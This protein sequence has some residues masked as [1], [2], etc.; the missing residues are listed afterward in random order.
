M[1]W[2]DR[3][4]PVA[5]DGRVRVAAVLVL[6]LVSLVAVPARAYADDLDVDP[7]VTLPI[8]LIG[9]STY[10]AGELVL[11]DEISPSTCRW[12]ASNR[13][14][15]GIRDGLRWDDTNLAHQ[16]SNLTGFAAAPVVAFGGIALL[17]EL[18]DDAG[19]SFGDDA[20]VILEAAV[21]TANINYVIKAAVGRERPF[22]HALPA[23]DKPHT[24][25]PSDNNLSF[26]SGHSAWSMSLAVSAGT[27][28]SIRGYDWAPALWAG[29]VGVSL[30]TGYLRIAADK[31]WATDVLVG[32]AA[33][34]AV[35]YL[36]PRL[37][38]R[39]D[40]T[41]APVIAVGGGP[42]APTLNLSFTW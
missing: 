28:A 8:V 33:G 17:G 12:C 41:G 10:A 37:H 42:R 2:V 35:G 23:A 31:H 21:I 14:D 29:G 5:D 13:F 25:A 38:R 20:L 6:V 11:K 3:L 19:G 1:T 36:V 18:D 16:L 40:P 34:A 27:V 7:K 26:Y 30:A 24:K 39:D 9:M 22:V 32:W 4:A 15:D